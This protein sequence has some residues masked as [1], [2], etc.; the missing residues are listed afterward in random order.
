M[1]ETS[2]EDVP[3]PTSDKSTTSNTGD[4]PPQSS[5]SQSDPAVDVIADFGENRETLGANED[6]EEVDNEVEGGNDE[7]GEDEDEAEQYRQARAAKG[8]EFFGRVHPPPNL[9]HPDRSHIFVRSTPIPDERQKDILQ[10]WKAKMAGDGTSEPSPMGDHLRPS[11][12]PTER[13][14]KA[15]QQLQEM[16]IEVTD[17]MYRTVFDQFT[18]NSGLYT[19]LQEYAS[20]KSEIPV[21]HAQRL[22]RQIDRL[23]MEFAA[24]IARQHA[25]NKALKKEFDDFKKRTWKQIE[26]LETENKQ[27]LLNNAVLRK[28][29]DDNNDEIGAKE[30]QCRD[31]INK[32]KSEVTQ[33]QKNVK[34][35]EAENEGLNGMM[36]SMIASQASLENQ[37]QNSSGQT[38]AAVS[39]ELTATQEN[40]A[41][42]WTERNELKAFSEEFYKELKREQTTWN[43]FIRAILSSEENMKQTPLQARFLVKKFHDNL[44]K[45]EWKFLMT[46]PGVGKVIQNSNVVAR[47]I[48]TAKALEEGKRAQRKKLAE[49]MELNQR[50]QELEAQREEHLR[51]IGETLKEP[52]I[53]VATD[54]AEL[55]GKPAGYML[56]P[57]DPVEKLVG[58]DDS[59]WQTEQTKK[60]VE[61]EVQSPRR[62]S[63]EPQEGEDQESVKSSPFIFGDEKKEDTDIDGN[64]PLIK[65]NSTPIS[66]ILGS[67]RKGSDSHSDLGDWEPNPQY[68]GIPGR[69][70]EIEPTELPETLKQDGERSDSHSDLGDWAPNP[71]YRGIPGW[72]YE[73]Q[74]TETSGRF[75]PGWGEYDMASQ[76]DPAKRELVQARTEIKI[77]Q[78]RVRDLDRALDKSK[79]D[80]QKGL[81]STSGELKPQLRTLSAL[82]GCGPKMKD[83]EKDKEP[84]AMAGRKP[85]PNHV[86][87]LNYLSIQHMFHVRVLIL[88]SFQLDARKSTAKIIQSLDIWYHTFKGQLRAM[89]GDVMLE[90]DGSRQV[91]KA[92]WHL[93]HNGNPDKARELG[94]KGHEI[95]KRISKPYKTEKYLKLAENLDH[96]IATFKRRSSES[97]TP[98]AAMNARLEKSSSQFSKFAD[99]SEADI[100]RWRDEEAQRKPPPPPRPETEIVTADIFKPP[101]NWRP[102]RR[103]RN[104]SGE[105]GTDSADIFHASEGHAP[106]QRSELVHEHQQDQQNQRNQPNQENQEGQGSQQSQRSGGRFHIV[107]ARID[108]AP[109]QN[110]PLGETY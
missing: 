85:K 109:D 75:S 50:L 72:S 26:E 68:R 21:E 34:H 97:L 74:P 62:R 29:L 90:V 16:G 80:H 73:A 31:T 82:L 69:S 3:K 35:L 67:D 93:L 81:C 22:V 41:L 38:K 101:S 106:S 14:E 19:S 95:L 20:G 12:P 86:D 9:G 98:R 63:N 32:L 57:S 54:M 1:S 4:T 33:L 53:S 108:N 89:D 37:P 100:Q 61:K 28:D 17:E 60:G 94:S 102:L 40:L 45:L 18:E 5:Y 92:Y 70:K 76:A 47:D 79:R 99:F 7:V 51:R 42:V 78:N 104:N 49:N 25:I 39:D 15:R 64:K 52:E 24:Q 23:K 43:T 59:K 65:G 48:L 10:R 87:R 46:W 2:L 107:N 105:A 77:L 36:A 55:T 11:T 103:T 91:L 58:V 96:A 88:E 44:E 56:D 83:S 13:A 6:V 66:G 110:E 71:E 8:R 27:L 30:E 84:A